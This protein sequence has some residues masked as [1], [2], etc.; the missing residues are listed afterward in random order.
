VITE[1]KHF[2]KPIAKCA[3]EIRVKEGFQHVDPTPRDNETAEIIGK[4]KTVD[5]II[6]ADEGRMN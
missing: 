2:S 1:G 4:I 5:K 6:H 3:N